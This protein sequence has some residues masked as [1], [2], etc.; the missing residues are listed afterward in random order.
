MS[1][2]ALASVSA[3]GGSRGVSVTFSPQYERGAWR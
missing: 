3:P 1:G 2:E